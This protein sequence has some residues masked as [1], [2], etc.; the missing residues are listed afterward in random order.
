MKNRVLVIGD[1]HEPCSR[2]GYL[3]FCQDIYEQ[4]DCNRVVFI[5]D[6][7]DWH[8]IS[9]H[10]RHP[11]AP[12]VLDEYQLAFESIHR[13]YDAFPKAQICKGNHDE[14]IIRLAETVDIPAKFLRN[15]EEIWETPGWDWVFETTIDNVYYFHGTGFGGLYPSFNVA[16][17]MGC[18]TVMGHVHSV[19]GIK[20]MV[21]PLSRW[22]GMDV[23][24]GIDDKKF[25]FA[26]GKHMKKKSVISCGVVIDGM[27][28][29]ELMPLEK[30]TR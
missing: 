24:C 4:W 26:Y 9:F 23:G 7:V 3:E 25:A 16:R 30:F 21:G 8:G 1:I 2:K 28:Y 29:L 22:F 15:Y 5:G 18:S 11:E 13:W 6:V 27:P 19:A 10:A 20:W 17:S 14:R 12:G